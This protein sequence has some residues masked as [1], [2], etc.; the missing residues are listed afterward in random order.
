MRE[1]MLEL[2]SYEPFVEAKGVEKT[3][4]N[5]VL[6][7]WKVSDSHYKTLFEGFYANKNNKDLSWLK[8]WVQNRP[9]TSYPVL[10]KKIAYY[11]ILNLG[12]EDTEFLEA[13]GIKDKDS[14][15]GKNLLTKWNLYSRYRKASE[16]HTYCDLALNRNG[17]KQEYLTSFIQKVYYEAHRQSINEERDTG[18]T[19]SVFADAFTNLVNKVAKDQGLELGYD[20]RKIISYK[21]I[22]ATQKGLPLFCDVF[23]GTGIV[24]ASINVD[25]EKKVVNDFDKSM[26][27]LIYVLR[28]YKLELLNKIAEYHNLAMSGNLGVTLYTSADFQRHIPKLTDYSEN[29]SLTISKIRRNEARYLVSSCDKLLFAPSA[30]EVRAGK[31]SYTAEEIEAKRAEARPLVIRNVDTLIKMRNLFKYCEQVETKGLSVAKKIDLNDPSSVSEKEWESFIDYCACYYIYSSFGSPSFDNTPDETGVDFDTYAV[32]LEKTFDIKVTRNANGFSQPIEIKRKTGENLD[33]YI[34]GIL[35]SK[36]TSLDFRQVFGDNTAFYYLDSH[37]FLTKQYNSTFTDTMHKDML[38]IIRSANFKYLFSMQ[39]K[40]ADEVGTKQKARGNIYIKDYLEYF[41]GFLADFETK[42][43]YYISTYDKAKYYKKVY[44]IFMEKGAKNMPT[45]EIFVTNVD[46]RRIAP[47]GGNY[48]QLPLKKLVEYME[49]H[50]TATYK[51]VLAFAKAEYE[52][53][54]TP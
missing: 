25:S 27:V 17:K 20:N 37:Y 14:N 30:N 24:S 36:L 28:Y 23:S 8:T 46:C 11:L 41:K 51:D 54:L 29:K 43:N 7:G 47:Y 39:Y 10:F 12:L 40:K 53:E 1:V 45:S 26:M 52:S 34:K 6:K 15:T 38:D 35:R 18:V 5:R 49:N 42:G 21:E 44:V 32:F 4:I 3:Y 13:V 9:T 31:S 22:G 16:K 19:D 48:I 33:A 50:R 2:L